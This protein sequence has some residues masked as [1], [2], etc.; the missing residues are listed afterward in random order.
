LWKKKGK[1]VRIKVC[2]RCG[3]KNIKL[4]STFD[5]W[6]TPEVYLCMECGYRGTI[7]LELEVDIRKL[8]ED[9]DN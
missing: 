9:E 8:K 7:I 2:P 6:I 5:G 4:S 3:S 1:K